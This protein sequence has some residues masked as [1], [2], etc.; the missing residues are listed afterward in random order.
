MFL[1]FEG[2]YV[3]I[4]AENDFGEDVEMSAKRSEIRSGD[5]RFFTG[6]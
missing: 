1:Q 5:R 4:K 3:S 6:E 2:K